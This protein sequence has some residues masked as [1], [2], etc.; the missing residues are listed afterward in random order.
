[1]TGH[2]IP[3]P[4]LEF[5]GNQRHVDIRYGLTDH[6]P[7]D[8]GEGG[9]KEVRL[10]VVGTSETVNG[11]GKWLERCRSGIPAKKSRFHHLYAPFSGFGE[12]TPLPAPLTISAQQEV[13]SRS[14]KGLFSEA[15]NDRA[16]RN[17]TDLFFAELEHLDTNRGSMCWY[18]PRPSSSGTSWTGG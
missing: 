8:A 9:P 11:F 17:A 12:G 18:V 1:M 2:F 14:V 15:D 7:L 10:G 5:G 6:G 13:S 3:E 16:I 4:E